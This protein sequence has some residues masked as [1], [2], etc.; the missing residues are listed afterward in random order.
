MAKLILVKSINQGNATLESSIPRSHSKSYFPLHSRRICL[1]LL[2][3]FNL[4]DEIRF[5][6]NYPHEMLISFTTSYFSLQ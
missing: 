4:E 3:R 5:G 2:L 1:T 6:Q